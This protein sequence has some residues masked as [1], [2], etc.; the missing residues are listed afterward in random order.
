MFILR[1]I[2]TFHVISFKF[3]HN[4]GLLFYSMALVFLGIPRN[5]VGVSEIEPEPREGMHTHSITN[6][7]VTSKL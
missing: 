1:I 4:Y 3:S 6:K 5:G 7:S 2:T